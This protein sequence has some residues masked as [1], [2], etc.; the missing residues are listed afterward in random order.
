[1]IPL[2]LY[3]LFINIIAFL[4]MGADKRLARKSKRRIPEATLFLA[5]VLGGA[6]GIIAGMRIFRHKTRHASFNVGMPLIAFFELALMCALI[7]FYIN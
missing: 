6:A 1:M 7:Y 3:L 5:A 4:L 2:A